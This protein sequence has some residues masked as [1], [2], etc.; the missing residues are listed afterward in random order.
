MQYIFMLSVELWNDRGHNCQAPKH[1]LCCCYY[2]HTHTLNSIWLLQM[3][4]L[5]S[6]IS[7]FSTLGPNSMSMLMIEKHKQTHTLTPKSPV[8]IGFLYHMAVI[9]LYVLF[10]DKLSNTVIN[11][12]GSNALQK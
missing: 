9:A 6:V 8:G 4:L 7:G 11:S 12:V 10:E 5:Y 3:L 2:T 1:A